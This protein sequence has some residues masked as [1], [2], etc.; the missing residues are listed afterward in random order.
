MEDVR[1]V[2]VSVLRDHHAGF[3]KRHVT[4]LDIG[5]TVLLGKTARV[6]GIM[7]SD[8]QDCT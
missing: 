5:R 6:E 2:E 3:V 1:V 8:E 7:S 4:D